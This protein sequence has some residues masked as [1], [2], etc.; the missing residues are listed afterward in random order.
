MIGGSARCAPYR[1]PRTCDT[2]PIR[3]SLSDLN[4]AGPVAVAVGAANQPPIFP[5]L[6]VSCPPHPSVGAPHGADQTRA[7]QAQPGQGHPHHGAPRALWAEP[8]GRGQARRQDPGAAE[9]DVASVPVGRG[10]AG[11]QVLDQRARVGDPGQA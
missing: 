5:P 3:W 2:I 11:H 9:R 10:L 6:R 8:A 1:C 4:V 7:G